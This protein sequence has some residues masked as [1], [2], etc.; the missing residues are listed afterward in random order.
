MAD[1]MEAGKRRRRKAFPSRVIRC[2]ADGD[3]MVS[4]FSM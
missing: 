4:F 3:A 1:G 2:Q